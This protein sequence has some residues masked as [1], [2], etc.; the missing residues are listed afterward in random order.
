MEK[1]LIMNKNSQHQVWSTQVSEF[2]HRQIFVIWKKGHQ[3]CAL[4]FTV[5]QWGIEHLKS[6]DIVKLHAFK[7]KAAYV[8]KWVLCFIFYLDLLVDSNFSQWN[9]PM[10]HL[11]QLR[12]IFSFHIHRKEFLKIVSLKKVFIQ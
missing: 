8:L 7:K 1:L 12:L 2:I 11:W 6:G 5:T 4:L 3:R 9:Q 10:K